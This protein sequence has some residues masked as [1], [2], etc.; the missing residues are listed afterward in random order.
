MK[1]ILRL[2]AKCVENLI[3][4]KINADLKTV[5]VTY[6]IVKD[7]ISSVC[8]MKGQTGNKDKANSGK[9]Y[10]KPESKNYVNNQSDC[11]DES[12]DEIFK[13]SS[14]EGN[15]KKVR[16]YVINC[17]LDKVPVPFEIDTGSGIST[18]REEDFHRLKSVL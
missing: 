5:N 17:E 2:N 7:I 16:P 13:I 9:K 10:S 8:R 6:V 15:N 12:T 3:I 14:T 11:S 4:L 1:F 18:I